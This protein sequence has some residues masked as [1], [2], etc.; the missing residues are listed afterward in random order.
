M[1]TQ[2]GADNSRIAYLRFP[3][4]GIGPIGS[5]TLRLYG[6]SSTGKPSSSVNPSSAPATS[7]NDACAA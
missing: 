7:L 1:K 3:L 2:N 4:P 5:A 6:K